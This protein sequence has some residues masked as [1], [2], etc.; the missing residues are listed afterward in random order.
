VSRV[1]GEKFFGDVILMLVRREEGK[2]R[3]AAYGEID[4]P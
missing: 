2:Y 4:A 3:I 1:A